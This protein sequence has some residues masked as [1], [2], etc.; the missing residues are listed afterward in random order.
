MLTHAMCQTWRIGCNLA[1]LHPQP[2]RQQTPSDPR[3]GCARCNLREASSCAHPPTPIR[4][5]SRPP[6]CWRHEHELFL[7]NVVDMKAMQTWRIDAVWNQNSWS[8]CTHETSTP[9]PNS[10]PDARTIISNI[11][12]FA[13]SF[14]G[15]NQNDRARG[16]SSHTRT[17][18]LQHP[19]IAKRRAAV[20]NHLKPHFSFSCIS[21]TFIRM[22]DFSLRGFQIKG[23]I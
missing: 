10:P 11:Y 23:N 1:F 2:R 3:A 21:R 18:F 22:G 19:K 17:G 5:S 20:P 16:S 14:L 6:R 9:P 8:T 4:I 12:I 13:V 7:T 15:R